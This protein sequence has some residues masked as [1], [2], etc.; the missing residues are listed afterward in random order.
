MCTIT[1]GDITFTAIEMAFSIR[2]TNATTNPTEQL[3]Q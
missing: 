1:K 3:Q 2:T